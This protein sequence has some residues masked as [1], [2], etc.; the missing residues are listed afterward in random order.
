MKRS[1]RLAALLS[2]ISLVVLPAPARA[3]GADT[4]FGVITATLSDPGG[5]NA[6]NFI[7]LY[8]L[9]RARYRSPIGIRLFS[10]GRLPLPGKSPME[11]KLMDWAI[12]EHPE[13]LITVS[14]KISDL[15]RL[16]E[17]LDLV[18]RRRL[19]VSIIYFHEAQADYF[20]D[21]NPA[22]EPATYRRVY[23]EYRA[24][25]DRHPAR[26]RVT[27]EKNLMW[28]WQHARTRQFR[29][30]VWRNYVQPDDP[31][32]LLS[33]DTYTFPGVDNR[34]RRYSTPDE[35]FR[36]ARD[37][38]RRY[39]LA[40]GV[41]EIGTTVQDGAGAER[42]WDRDGARFAAWVREITAAAANPASIG[43][44]YAGMPPAEFVKWWCAMDRNG[45]E[46]CLDQ[47]P[48]A[49]AVYQPLVRAHPL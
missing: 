41:G 48:A 20:K 19:R 45:I 7:R 18:Q 10:Q 38:W 8:E 40:W 11:A 14:H 17:F 46:Y 28:Y 43:P 32:D 6:A 16:D 34:Q 23:R 5:D 29:D 42:D 9:Q 44:S 3:A 22:A 12:R 30:S 1:R 26:S 25:I 27:L 2:A 47:T 4:R 24:R 39:G 21:R 37:A 49:E 36:Y 15:D 13:E 31:A 33:W 35:F